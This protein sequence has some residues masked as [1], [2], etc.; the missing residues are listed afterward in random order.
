MS[1][2]NYKKAVQLLNFFAE[3]EGGSIDKIK[4]IKLVWLADRA[5]LRKFGRPITFDSYFAM[6]HGPVPSSTKDLAGENSNFLSPNEK[7]YRDAF[8]SV[9]ST[10]ITAISPLE[11]DVLSETEVQI[12][13]GIYDEFG[14]DEG[15]SLADFSHDYPEW[16]KFESSLKFGEKSRF[17]MDYL[18]FFQNPQKSNDYFCQ[19]VDEEDLEISKA[20]FQENQ[21]LTQV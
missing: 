7:A 11:S 15:F 17:A 9:Q 20:L 19:D 6:A 13:N 3:K 18:D 1:G 14:N 21:A 12:L 16:N 10:R 5:H 4:T 2:F 8:I